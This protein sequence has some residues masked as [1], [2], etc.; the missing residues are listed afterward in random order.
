VWEQ[1]S[2]LIDSELL[3]GTFSLEASLATPPQPLK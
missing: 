3:K 2:S 1:I